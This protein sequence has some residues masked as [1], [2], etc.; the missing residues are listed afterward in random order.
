MASQKHQ[1]QSPFGRSFQSAIGR[2]TPM[3]HA[4]T[5]IAKRTGKTEHHV[6]QSLH[7]GGHIHRQKLN[8]Q[9]LYWPTH[10]TKRSASIAKQSQV[11]VWQAFVEW[12]I[13]GGHVTPEQI[14]SHT[15][16]QQQF[17]SY[18]RRF[19]GKQFPSQTQKTSTSSRSRT[20][21]KARSTSRTTSKSGKTTKSRTL[22]FQGRSTGTTRRYRRAA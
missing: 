18:I 12:A 17:L 1:H 7:K 11:E 15:G 4:V 6:Y 19:W 22:R 13:A 3:T 2:G 21:T 16:S 5:N 20:T 14:S 9:W 8:G 10:G